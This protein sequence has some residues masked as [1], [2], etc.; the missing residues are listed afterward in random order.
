MKNF[1]RWELEDVILSGELK[2]FYFEIQLCF[3]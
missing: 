2:L 1:V 3:I